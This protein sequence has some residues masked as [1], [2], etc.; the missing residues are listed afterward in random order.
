[1]ENWEDR[2]DKMFKQVWKEI[3][4]KTNKVRI[5]KVER[6]RRKERKE[7]KR[8]EERVQETDS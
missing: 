7:T 6:E 3:E 1:M 8:K 4:N 2:N 5:A